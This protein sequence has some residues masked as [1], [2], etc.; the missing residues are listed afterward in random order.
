MNKQELKLWKE[1]CDEIKKENKKIQKLMD[2]EK[3]EIELENEKF[4]VEHSQRVSR[5]LKIHNEQQS[6]ETK[7]LDRYLNLPWYKKWLEPYPELEY[8]HLPYLGLAPQIMYFSRYSFK[9]PTVEDFN[10]WCVNKYL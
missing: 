1:Y 3:K 4:R 5:I 8:I 9:E 7:K 6:K 2:K 10:N